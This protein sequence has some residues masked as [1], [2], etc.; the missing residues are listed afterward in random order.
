LLPDNKIFRGHFPGQPVLPGA[1]MLQ[2]VKE[3]LEDQLHPTYRLQKADNLK[4]L[5][6]VDPQLHRT[7]YLDLNYTTDENVTRVNATVNTNEQPAFK[8]QATFVTE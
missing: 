8:L 6:L 7:L 4:F 1:C 3:V 2:M 5:S